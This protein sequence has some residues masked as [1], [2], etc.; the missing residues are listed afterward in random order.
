MGHSR[1][2]EGLRVW[3]L[4]PLTGSGAH[5][6]LPCGRM[7]VGERQRLSDA[8]LCWV[9]S[10]CACPS[11]SWESDGKFMPSKSIALRLVVN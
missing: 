9:E 2:E 8:E 7:V 10:A 6:A 11:P 4:A 1:W 3:S 5:P